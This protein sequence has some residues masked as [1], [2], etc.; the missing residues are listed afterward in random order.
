[1][2]LT[3]TYIVFY[4]YRVLTGV[5]KFLFLSTQN[6]KCVKELEGSDGQTEIPLVT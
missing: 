3:D 4:D 1:M 5:F 2:V 6:E